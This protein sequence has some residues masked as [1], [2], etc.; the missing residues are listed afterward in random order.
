MEGDHVVHELAHWMTAKHLGCADDADYGIGLDGSRVVRTSIGD[1]SP[2]EIE[3]RVL[4]LAKDIESVLK[5]IRR[6]EHPK[7][8]P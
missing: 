3:F 2:E 6:I 4:Q 5:A 8:R 1:L 7:R